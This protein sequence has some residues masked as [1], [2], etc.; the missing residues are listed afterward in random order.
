LSTNCFS[1]SIIFP[2][3]FAIPNRVLIVLAL[4]AVAVLVA[5]LVGRDVDDIKAS[6]VAN[7]VERIQIME[8][9]GN[10]LKNELLLRKVRCLL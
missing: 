9:I 1:V 8:I 10:I 6:V 3:D 2:P 7:S 5:I 4:V